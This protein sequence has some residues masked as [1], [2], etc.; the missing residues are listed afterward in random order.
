MFG[1]GGSQFV[2]NLGGGP[3]IRVHQFGGGRPR[4]R[5]REANGE[6]EGPQSFTSL[7]T[8]LMPLLIL[9]VL[10]LLS[11]IFSGGETAPSLPDFRFQSTPPYTSARTT[12]RYKVKYFVNKRDL[13]DLSSRKL[14][15][16]DQRAETSYVST[17]QYNCQSE[18]IT[19][20]R[21]MQD[22]QGWFFSDEERLKEAREMDL[23]NCVRLRNL[24]APLPNVGAY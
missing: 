14:T 23:T 1:G 11:S 20:N 3:G 7:L 16:L 10:P 12:T 9:F 22:A 21:L 18:M 24:G 15:Q 17:L 19:R 13:E 8:S 6:D 4:R 2:F 5:P